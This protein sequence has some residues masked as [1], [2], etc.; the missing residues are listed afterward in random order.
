MAIP[1]FP[2][3]THG[4]IMASALITR[5]HDSLPQQHLIVSSFDG[6]LY[7]IDGK[8][9]CADTYYLGAIFAYAHD[10]HN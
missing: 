6:H 3:R 9:A 1:G 7:A 2:F 4:R 8:T 5:L 10:L